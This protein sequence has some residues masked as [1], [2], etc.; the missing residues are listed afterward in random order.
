MADNHRFQESPVSRRRFVQ[1][2]A[3]TTAALTL[4]GN[5]T[6]NAAAEAFS[7][8]YQYVLNHTP[9]EYRASTLI[10][11]TDTSGIHAL[12]RQSFGE[13]IH[14]TTT[15]VPAVYA[16]LTSAE[17]EQ[18]ASIPEAESF[19]FSPGSNPFW[20]IGYY[21][22]GVFPEPRRSVDF[23]GFEQLKDGL[24]ELETRYPDRV[25]V[26]NVGESP[27]HQNN[28]T[29]RPDPKGMY[30]VEVTNFESK[31]SFADKEKVFYACSLHGL[32]AAGRE[33]GARVVENVARGSEPDIAGNDAKIEPLLDDVVVIIGFVNPD[34]WA[35]RNP[36]YDSGW[37]VGGPGTDFPRA[38]A[39]PVYERGNAEVF[40]TN[41]QYP[42]VGAI[43]PLHYPA[44][45]PVDGGPEDVP[46]FVY[47]K[48]PDAAAFVEFFRT[49]ENLNYGADL[50]GGPVFNEFV[51][52]LISQDQFDTRQLHELYEMC[53][54]IDETLSAA[55]GTWQTAGDIRTELIGEGQY[56]PELYGVLPEEAF[57]YATIYDTIGYTVSGAMLDW[58]AHPEPVGLDMTTLDFEM[59]F[60]HMVGGNVFHPELYEMEVTGYRT[61]IRTI[62]AFAV[63]NSSTPSTTDQFTATTHADGDRVAYVTTGDVVTSADVLSRTDDDL[64]FA[65]GDETD[66]ET[67]EETIPE[68]ISPAATTTVT[69]TVTGTALHSLRVHI[70][71]QHALLDLALE[72]PSG[73]VVR[74]FEAITDDRVG[75]KCCGFPEWVIT[76]PSPGTW[77]LTAT[78]RGETTQAVDAYFGTFA[79]EA[80]NPD[81]RAVDEWGDEG[82]DQRA[83]TVSPFRFFED[84]NG[85]IAPDDTGRLEPVTVAAVADGVLQEED[86]DHAVIIHD[87]GVNA[88]ADYLCSDIPGYTPADH[89]ADGFDEPGYVA[90]LDEFVDTGG[91]LVLT[92]TGIHLLAALENDLIAGDLTRDDVTI[93]TNDVARFFP[94]TEEPIPAQSEEPKNLEHPLLTDV[95][96]IQNQLWKVAPLGYEV[97]NEAPMY[98]IDESAYRAAANDGEATV[99][100]SSGGSVA[101]GSITESRQSGRGIH[102]I[103][104]LLPPATQKNLHPFGLQNYTVTFLGNLMFTSALG[105]EQVRETATES[106]VFG[107]GDSWEFDGDNGENGDTGPTATGS[108]ETDS[109]L[110][111][112]ANA[113]RVTV[114]LEDV[115]G[116]DDAV[117]IRDQFPSEWAFQPAFSDGEVIADG[118]VSFGTVDPAAVA[119][120]DTVSHTYFIESPSDPAASGEYEVGPATIDTADG[121]DSFAGTATVYVLA[122][123]I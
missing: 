105:W 119:D 56:T 110:Q 121:T 29:D 118:V 84:Y 87:Y 115:T 33:T 92:D 25:C 24:S 50:H 34:G 52:G 35:V 18:A 90:A 100:A 9:A 76:D 41:R 111:T 59:A 72:S 89:P 22:A 81:P 86:F 117:E 114:H 68:E 5:A 15:P 96:P 37:Q 47:E 78:N 99:A 19:Q 48:V 67:T 109:S 70:H 8:E 83:Y 49:Y 79:S 61:A 120:D 11:F 106:R 73:D 66:G 38:P 44:Y 113:Y 122:A 6:A 2:S 28:V 51:L 14:T 112:G 116:T 40:D 16:Q 32:E 55:L 36:Q 1:L 88:D 71:A 58:M 108:R 94:P 95:R 53:L 4:P 21:P 93:T 42:I 60:N 98:L 75:G 39:A 46:S 12:A 77:T 30:V 69:H 104:S 64:V 103:S 23:I 63:R 10:T 45:V 97:N 3:V 7:A 62:T 43:N 102:L 123:D 80:T 20:R 85:Y 31:T 13:E 27:G 91:N 17:A 101:A 26:R 54:V 82:Y 74:S 65:E 57:D 107:R